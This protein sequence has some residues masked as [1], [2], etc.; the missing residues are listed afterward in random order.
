VRPPRATA[1]AAEATP[2]DKRIR[3]VCRLGRWPASR[4]LPA[5]LTNTRMSCARGDR[6]QCDVLY[7]STHTTPPPILAC[8]PPALTAGLE[9]LRTHIGKA[10]PATPGAAQRALRLPGWPCWLAG[11]W[12]AVTAVSRTGFTCA[13]LRPAFVRSGAQSLRS[14][15]N[16][17]SITNWRRDSICCLPPGR[18]GP[19]TRQATINKSAARHRS[20]PHTCTHTLKNSSEAALRMPGE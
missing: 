5:T 17:H 3:L 19:A 18:G 6:G 12:H 16:P 20:M 14:G 10:V 9:H 2:A 1:R 11:M 15:T 8:S 4:A 13:R 7:H